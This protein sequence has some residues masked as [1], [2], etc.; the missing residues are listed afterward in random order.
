MTNELQSYY[1]IFEDKYKKCKSKKDYRKLCK[2]ML[3]QFKVI[4]GVDEKK[5]QLFSS[6]IGTEAYIKILSL[7]VKLYLLDQQGIRY[8]VITCEDLINHLDD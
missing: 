4:D 8:D 5:W 7:S 1:S 2:F 3:R 6:L